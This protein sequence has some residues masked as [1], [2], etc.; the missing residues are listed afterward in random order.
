MVRR[1]F[2][3]FD[4]DSIHLILT[5]I[6]IISGVFSQFFMVCR[7]IKTQDYLSRFWKILVVTSSAFMLGPT[8]INAFCIGDI[9]VFKLGL[10]PY[11]EGPNRQT[12]SMVEKKVVRALRFSSQAKL[13]ELFSE[14][15]PQFFTQLIMT[16][17]KGDGGSRELTFLQTLS[18][19]SSAI[20]I[21]LGISNYIIESAGRSSKYF[22]Y[23]HSRMTTRLVLVLVIL[24]ELLFCGGIRLCF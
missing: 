1:I 17:A 15:V 8:M 12:N 21:S 19:T 5:W 6:W 3:D 18:V 10:G 11:S 4:M 14:S 2:A 7:N 13:G 23:N 24:L 16:S 9:V 22:S 20:S